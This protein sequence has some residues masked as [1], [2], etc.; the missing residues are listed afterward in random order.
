MPL[1]LRQQLAKYYDGQGRAVG[2]SGKGMQRPA[3]ITARIESDLENTPRAMLI[4]QNAEPSSPGII[5]TV[6]NM[7]TTYKGHGWR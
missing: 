7:D 3:F 6:D 4:S 2:L 1:S 5:E